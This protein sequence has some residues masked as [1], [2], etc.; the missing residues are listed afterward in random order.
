MLGVGA[1]P[2]HGERVIA[3]GCMVTWFWGRSPRHTL[4]HHTR[5][6]TAAAPASAGR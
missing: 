2:S 5:A 4:G 1:V 6:S 3:S